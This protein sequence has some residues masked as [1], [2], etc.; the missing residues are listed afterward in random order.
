[1]TQDN[2]PLRVA[3]IA[4]IYRYLSHAQHFCDRLLVGYPRAGAWH[5]PN[6]TIASL[7]LDQRPSNDQSVDRAREFGFEIY[8]TIAEALRC[9]GDRLAVDAV[10]IVCEHGDYPRNEKGQSSIPVTS[11]SRRA[12]RSLKRMV[13]QYQFTTTSISPIALR[14]R[15]RW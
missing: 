3:V 8:P 4:S 6:M 15:R 9:G 11:F 10:M 13:A 5:R 1:M 2:R 14:K 7:Y 12:S